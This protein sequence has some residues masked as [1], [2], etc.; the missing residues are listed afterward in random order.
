MLNSVGFLFCC[1]PKK[2]TAAVL[3]FPG[4]NCDQETVAALTRNGFEARV[5]RWNEPEKLQKVDAIVIAGGFSFEDRGRSG[6]IASREGAMQAVAAA[7]AKGVVVLGIC[8]GAQV[9]VETGLVPHGQFG[10]SVVALAHNI[11]PGGETYFVNQWVDLVS[12]VA[13]GSNAFNDFEGVIRVPI[14]HG[15]GRFTTIDAGLIQHIVQNG[16][17]AFCY[18]TPAGEIDPTFPVNPNGSVLNLAGLTNAAGNVMALMPH[19]ERTTAGDPIFQ[20][21]RR[22]IQRRTKDEG[23]RTKLRVAPPKIVVQSVKP[24]PVE[25]FIKLKITDNE[26]LSVEQMVR[27][28]GLDVKLTKYRYV[29]CKDKGQGT[30]DKVSL[31]VLEKLIRSGEILNIE[32]EAVWVRM[33]KQTYH[34]H[35]TKGLVSETFA[36]PQPAVLAIGREAHGPRTDGVVW[37]LVE[38]KQAD[39]LSAVQ[40]QFFHHPAAQEVRK[41]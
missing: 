14:A 10:Q 24:L 40:H 12:P 2:P 23:R 41:M 21:M 16:Q 34:F 17:N 25:F 32:K 1:M 30:K 15:E 19:P 22:W 18:C 31:A 33:G 11:F 28:K 9:L 8:N 37:A 35:K 39:F 5:V 4:T 3:V 26:A 7:A 6:L 27:G 29:G 20:S 36:F 13:P 38:G